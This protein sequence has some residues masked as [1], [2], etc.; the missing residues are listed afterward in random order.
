MSTALAYIRV[1]SRSQDHSTQRAAI[2]RAALARGDEVSG[3]YSGK[4]S[5]MTMA[6]AELKRLLVDVR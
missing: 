2:E 5:A 6:R 1:S 4:R 3:W